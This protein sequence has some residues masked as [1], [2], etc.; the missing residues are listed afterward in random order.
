[1]P[2][3]AANRI[4]TVA[5]EIMDSANDSAIV[6]V[7]FSSSVYLMLATNVG[8]KVSFGARENLP[9]NPRRLPKKGND[10]PMTQVRVT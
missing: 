2:R 4:K 7:H 8:K 6:A 9:K 3:I 10:K 1:L 5:K